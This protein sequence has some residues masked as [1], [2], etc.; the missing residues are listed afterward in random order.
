MI[1]KHKNPQ[2]LKSKMEYFH[3]LSYNDK[4]EQ[5]LKLLNMR[6]KYKKQIKT[7]LIA[8]RGNHCWKN[9]IQA[10]KTGYGL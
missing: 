6:K 7:I 5:F 9:I 4:K 3:P 10:M 1:W 8:I 2:N